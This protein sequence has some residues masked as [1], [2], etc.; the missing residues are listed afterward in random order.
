MGINDTGKA[1]RGSKAKK[2]KELSHFLPQPIEGLPKTS[3]QQLTFLVH[4]MREPSQAEPLLGPSRSSSEIQHS[5]T[6][7]NGSKNV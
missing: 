4:M 7:F 6:G 3:K 2:D 5:S 1:V